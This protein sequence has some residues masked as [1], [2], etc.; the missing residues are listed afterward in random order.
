MALWRRHL[1]GILLLSAVILAVGYGFWPRPLMVD[2]VALTQGPMTVTLEEE[3]KTRVMDS[4]E[5]SAP[6]SGYARRIK[7]E[8]GEAV[9]Q[10]QVL[11]ILDPL[12]S[13]ALDPRSRAEAQARILAATSALK[14]AQENTKAAATHSEFAQAELKRI[15]PLHQGGYASQELLDQAK[16]AAQGTQAKLR[17][18]E[19][20]VEVSRFEVQAAKTALKY[21]GAK[22]LNGQPDKLPIHAPVDGQVLKIYRESEGVVNAGSPLI[23]IGDP[24]ALEVEVE[25]LS[26]D[27]VQIG[28]DTAVIFERWGGNTA[29]KGRV[30]V[31]EPSGFTKI[32]ALGVEEQRVRV[33]IDLISPLEQWRRLGDGY[34]IEASFILWQADSILQ[35]PSGALFRHGEDWAV[36]T[37]E[38]GR[39]IRRLVEIG[40]QNGLQAEVISGLSQDEMVITH[41]GAGIKDG[42]RVEVRLFP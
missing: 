17:S 13:G 9:E 16:A 21:A 24:S 20:A 27:A 18:A 34:R 25:V 2:A 14:A 19:F 26:E 10:G 39:A 4:F 30:R 8:V 42:V 1:G 3:G 15:T 7:L 11:V 6:V 38:D 28:A 23:K 37:L 35:V 40:H 5:I 36:F 12:R 22:D 41:P 32:S 31:V 33:I 29:L